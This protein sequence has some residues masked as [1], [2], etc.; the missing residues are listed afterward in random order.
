MAGTARRGAR[1]VVAA[2][3][4][5]VLAAAAAF[6]QSESVPLPTPDPRPKTGA[7][8]PWPAAAPAA[9]YAAPG[10]ATNRGFFSFPFSLDGG[11]AASHDSGTRTRRP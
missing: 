11:G 9:T 5:S 6:A 3:V 2:L 8:L 10:A 7:G 1:V 4:C